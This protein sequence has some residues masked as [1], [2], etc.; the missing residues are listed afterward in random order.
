MTWG[1][2]IVSLFPALWLLAVL[3]SS[4]RLVRQS[5]LASFGILF[6]AI[7]G[8]PLVCHRTHALFFPLRD[9]AY[10]LSEPRYSPWWASHMFQYPFIALPFLESALHFIPGGFSWWLRLWGSKI[11]SNVHWTPRVEIVDRGSIEVGNSCVFGHLSGVSSHMIVFQ[12]GRPILVLKR[13]R[14]GD[15]CLLG[16]ASH[17]GPGAEIAPGTQTRAKSSHLAREVSL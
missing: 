12:E 8:A 10:D 17:Y 4:A 7:Y 2:R 16:A 13:V 3:A 14:F 5:D 1:G 11:G 9:G 15:G 6:F